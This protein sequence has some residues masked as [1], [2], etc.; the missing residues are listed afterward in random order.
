MINA[1]FHEKAF[2]NTSKSDPLIQ[3]RS[4]VDNKT[5]ETAIE[6]NNGLARRVLNKQTNT[7]DT[8]KINEWNY[9]NR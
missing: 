6:E 5:N 3:V 8:T 4:V 1:T 7:S 2:D 9:Y